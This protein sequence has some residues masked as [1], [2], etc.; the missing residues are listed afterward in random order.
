AKAR[1]VLEDCP[2]ALRGWEW[3]YLKGRCEGVTRTVHQAHGGG[4]FALAADPLSARVAS[5]GEDGKIRFWD[6]ESGQ[7][8]RQLPTPPGRV[9][10]LAYSPDGKLM[11]AAINRLIVDSPEPIAAPKKESKPSPSPEDSDKGLKEKGQGR[12]ER[13]TPY[14]LA[15]AGPNRFLE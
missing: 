1:Q 7:E 4:V 3:D 14:L 8:I 9:R 10:S 5:A 11:V 2:S 6:P 15:L 13:L 12:T